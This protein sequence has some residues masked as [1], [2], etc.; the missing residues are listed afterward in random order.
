MLCCDVWC[1]LPSSK[2]SSAHWLLWT[3]AKTPLP[4]SHVKLPNVME[5][6]IF[7]TPMTVVVVVVHVHSPILQNQPELHRQ[8]R[9]TGS[10][11]DNIETKLSNVSGCIFAR[12]N[13][14]SIRVLFVYFVLLCSFPFVNDNMISTMQWWF[15]AS[16]PF[17]T[18]LRSKGSQD[19][20]WALWAV[21]QSC[22]IRL[23]IVVIAMHY[24]QR[25]SRPLQKAKLHSQ[26]CTFTL[27]TSGVVNQNKQLLTSVEILF[28]HPL[29]FHQAPYFCWKMCCP[30]HWWQSILVMATG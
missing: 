4:F 21:K 10:S 13:W 25:Y 22:H 24:S 9:G 11:A 3:A 26:Y 6:V 12:S 29:P 17:K 5:V 7:I 15:Q 30:L 16:K 19:R 8:Q 18:I 27:M 20:P 2:S 1:S 28:V 14:F 23:W